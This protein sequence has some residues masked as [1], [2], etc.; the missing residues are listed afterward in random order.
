VKGGALMSKSEKWTK[1]SQKLKDGTTLGKS[2]RWAK[3]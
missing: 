3:L 2:E 1:L